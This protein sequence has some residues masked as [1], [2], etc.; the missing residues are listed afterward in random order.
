MSANMETMLSH[1]ASTS[2]TT[3]KVV[4]Y[5]L[6]AILSDPFGATRLVVALKGIKERDGNSQKFQKL[7]DAV[8]IALPQAIRETNDGYD[9]AF[10]ATLAAM[11]T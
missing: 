1:W 8:W 5:V 4:S 6:S 9:A 2:G 3:E 11:K 7:A 10:R